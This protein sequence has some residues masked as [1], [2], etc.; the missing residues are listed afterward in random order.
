MGSALNAQPFTFRPQGLYDALDG[1]QVPPGA[2]FSLQNLV[3]DISTP[4]IWLG[5]PNVARLTNFS[6]FATPSVVSVAL[7]VGTRI[8]GM[9]GSARNFQQDEPFCFDTATNAFVTVANVQAANTPTTQATVGA[10][11]PPT[12]DAVGGRLLVT[13]PGFAGGATKFGWFDIS[14]FSSATIT[15]NTNSNTTINN[16]ATNVL[17]AGWQPGMLI[18]STQ[19]V[20]AGTYIVS[21]ATGG[22]SIV[23]SQAATNTTASLTFT[24]TGGTTAAPLWN[25]GDTNLNNLPSVPQAV[26]Q[27]NNRAYYACN[28]NAYYSDGLNPTNMTLASQFLTCG[29]SGSPI[30]GFG[31]LGVQQT[32]GGILAALM[33]F[34]SAGGY[35][36][37]TGDAATTTLQLNGPIGGVGCSAG[38]TIIQT[39][40]G[41]SFMANDGMRVIDFYGNVQEAPMPAVRSPF[42]QALVPSRACAAFNNTVL[43]VSLQTTP[44]V[45]TGASAFVDY[46]YDYEISQWGGPHTFAYD[47]AVPMGDSFVLASNRLPGA[48]Y[49]SNVDPMTTDNYVELGQP[50]SFVLQSTLFPQDQGMSMKAVVESQVNVQFGAATQVLTAQIVSASQGVAGQASIT[51]QLPTR[52]GQFIWGAANWSGALYGLKTYNID[53]TAPVVYKEAGCLFTGQLAQGFKIGAARFRTEELEY[54]NDMVPA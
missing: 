35:W 5:R 41:L 15:G 22:L 4:G 36:Q 37:I 44:N 53:W 32:Q 1:E 21:I 50:M 48:L 20:P 51:P 46:W 6:S 23:I 2:C 45:L 17:L 13:H 39:P 12:M 16:L 10:W 47:C 43:R 3:H 25:A 52:W 19:D 33:A 31:A 24:V 40:N 29:D 38:R 34:K 26:K 49:M 28:N 9:I 42:Q 8:Y 30:T 7:N 27:F 54:M 14:G 11:T 18:T